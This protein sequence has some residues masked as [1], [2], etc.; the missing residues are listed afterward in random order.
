MRLVPILPLLLATCFAC[1][2]CGGAEDAV[3]GT[4]GVVVQPEEVPTT[5]REAMERATKGAELSQ[6][7]KIPG[8]N[9]KMIYTARYLRKGK[10][11]TV[12]VSEDGKVV[13][14]GNHDREGNRKKKAP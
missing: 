12:A 2:A 5:V 4:R 7:Q 10:D 14:N 13:R 6:F 8:A 1:A 11:A 3:A 9:G